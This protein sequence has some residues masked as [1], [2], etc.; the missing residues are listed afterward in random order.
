MKNQETS[1]EKQTFDKSEMKR[2]WIINMKIN[3]E[4]QEKYIEYIKKIYI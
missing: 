4:Y 1:E 2:V 3:Q